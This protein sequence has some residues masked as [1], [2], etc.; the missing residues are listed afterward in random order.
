M[1]ISRS[2]YDKP[3]RCPVDTGPALRGPKDW[4]D[5]YGTAPDGGQRWEQEV[6]DRGNRDWTIDKTRCCGTWV[7][8]A[9]FCYLEPV[10]W[11]TAFMSPIHIAK[12]AIRDKIYEMRNP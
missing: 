9:N 12:R 6:Y 5:C 10:W 11:F 1:N 4:D 7:L 2:N 3:F 8:P